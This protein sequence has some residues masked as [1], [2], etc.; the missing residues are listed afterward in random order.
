MS[1][2]Q[3]QATDASDLTIKGS[4]VTLGHNCRAGIRTV[5]LSHASP[6]S[7]PLCHDSFYFMK[8]IL[9]LKVPVESRVYCRTKVLMRRRL[10]QRTIWTLHTRLWHN[11]FFGWKSDNF[12][13]IVQPSASQAILILYVHQEIPRF[14]FRKSIMIIIKFLFLSHPALMVISLCILVN[15]I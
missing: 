1:S 14:I 6:I 7:N 8:F 9:L 11:Y 5:D 15:N 4:T 3:L 2:L 10:C 13:I 12:G